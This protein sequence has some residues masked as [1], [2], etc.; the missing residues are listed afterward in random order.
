MINDSKYS[1][2]DSTNNGNCVIV[3]KSD[4]DIT[5]AEDGEW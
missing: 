5:C 4:C 2:C 3:D 1:D